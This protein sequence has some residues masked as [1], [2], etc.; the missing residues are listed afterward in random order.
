MPNDRAETVQANSAV[1]AALKN[2]ETCKRSSKGAHLKIFLVGLSVLGVGVFWGEHVS[3]AMNVFSVTVITSMVFIVLVVR[4]IFLRCDNPT[5]HLLIKTNKVVAMVHLLISCLMT[6]NSYRSV[7]NKQSPWRVSWK[8][9]K[10]IQGGLPE[11]SSGVREIYE[12]IYRRLFEKDTVE[13]QGPTVYWLCA[14]FSLM[15]SCAHLYSVLF[16]TRYLSGLQRNLNPIRWIEYCLTAGI[17]MVCLASVSNVNMKYELISVFA[18]TALTNMFGMAI[19]SSDSNNYKGVYMFVGFI[20]FCI[21][22]IIIVEKYAQY[23]AT[24]ADIESLVKRGEAGTNETFDLKWKAIKENLEYL[25]I[26]VFVVLVLFNLFPA[27]QLCQIAHPGKYRL[28]EFLFVLASLTSKVILNS[29]IFFLGNRPSSSAKFD[30]DIDFNIDM[31]VGT[32]GDSVEATGVSVEA[33]G[34]SV[35]ETSYSNDDRSTKRCVTLDWTSGQRD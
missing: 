23:G 17:M 31:P 20:P 35:E 22:W 26:L 21:P 27:I 1:T 8:K 30:R 33:T 28:G 25:K 7:K 11:S 14:L 9:E 15:T 10:T 19:E 29:G 13:V 34:V 12:E 3:Y 2:I 16:P 32:Y 4:E 18:F 24:F 5:E 6:Y